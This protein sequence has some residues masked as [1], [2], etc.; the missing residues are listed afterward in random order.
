MS[1]YAIGIIPLDVGTRWI[2]RVEAGFI[3]LDAKLMVVDSSA[4]RHLI[5][6]SGG[7]Y[8]GSFVLKSDVDL[9]V[10][11]YSSTAAGKLDDTAAFKQ[12]PAVMLLRSPIENGASWENNVGRFTVEDTRYKLK[13]GDRIFPRC[14]H[15]RLDDTSH[16]RNDFFL[17]ENVGL[18][19]ASVV[20]DNFGKVNL[21]L[22][23]FN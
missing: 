5:K 8:E 11:A 23:R 15:I 22:K 20:I 16:Q 18:M 10:V 4:G 21:T 9:Y 2:Y 19:R 1:N 7:K 3:K 12:F 13:I 6:F 14:I 17:K